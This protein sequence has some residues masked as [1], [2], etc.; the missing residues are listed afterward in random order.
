MVPRGPQTH[1]TEAY[2]ASPPALIIVDESGAVWTLGLQQGT[3]PKGEFAFSIMRNG[4][5]TGE[6]GSRI[7]RRNGKIRIFTSQ[8]W[9]NWSGRSFI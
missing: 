6:F 7:E 4:V 8:G 5:D 2:V 9:K 3:A 1:I